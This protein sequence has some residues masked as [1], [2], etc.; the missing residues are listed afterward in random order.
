[1]SV[2]EIVERQENLPVLVRPVIAYCRVEDMIRRRK[3]R[4]VI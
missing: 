4:V 3:I 2:C 1:M